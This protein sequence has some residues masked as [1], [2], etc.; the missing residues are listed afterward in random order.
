MMAVGESAA[1]VAVRFSSFGHGFLS[2]VY[3][4]GIDL[5]QPTVGIRGR[6]VDQLRT[7]WHWA[8][9]STCYVNRLFGRIV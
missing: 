5:G 3:E 6:I 8:F 9:R 7:D 1:G 4:I 2:G